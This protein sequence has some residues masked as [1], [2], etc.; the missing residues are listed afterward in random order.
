M[1]CLRPRTYAAALDE[2]PALP[3]GAKEQPDA[4]GDRENDAE[5]LESN[6]GSPK[7]DDDF[8]SLDEVSSPLLPF[9]ES[10]SVTTSSAEHPAQPPSTSEAAPS[11]QPQRNKDTTQPLPQGERGAPNRITVSQ[12]CSG[13]PAA[14]PSMT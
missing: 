9:G 12:S 8:F 11:K 3:S 13:R 10:D 2:F 1:D 6:H 4:S 14:M 5:D 7:D